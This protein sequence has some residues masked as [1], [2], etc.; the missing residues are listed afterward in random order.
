[1]SGAGGDSIFCPCALARWAAALAGALLI[2]AADAF[3]GHAGALAQSSG[4]QGSGQSTQA[5]TQ[6]LAPA[7][8][9][10]RR[11]LTPG[12][13]E[14]PLTF[15]PLRSFRVREREQTR[16]GA[17]E[18]RGGGVLYSPNPHMGGLSGLEGLDGGKRMIAISD[19]GLWFGFDLKI[20]DK[21][22]LTGV[23][24]G[25]VAPMLDGDGVAM[26]RKSEADTEGLALRPRADGGNDL[27]VSFEGMPRILIYPD[28]N[29][30]AGREPLPLPADAR[31]YLRWNR[32]LESLAYAE[33]GPLKGATVAIGEL[34]RDREDRLPGWII[35]P[36][37]H[38]RPFALLAS[39]NYAA[40]DAAFLPDG[41]LLLLERRFN[42]TQG[43]GMRIRRFDATDLDGADG[44]KG[45]VL[46]DA[47]LAY[48]IDNMEG[49]S[50]DVDE[51][52][53]V[54][55]TV[56]SDDNRSILQRTLLIRFELL[57]D[58]R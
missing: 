1:M 32:G 27:M 21:G 24:D 22:M 35:G 48:Q 18:W 56:V 49:L 34:D 43:V 39:D 37:G 2:V 30:A 17:L 4:A 25:W 53:R 11:S 44:L 5:P 36:D 54:L 50:V 13:H 51:R 58:P 12:H 19:N 46:I 52:G 47:N 20:D 33:A 6:T 14:L 10:D 40:T 42:L 26:I 45:E 9:M 41:D 29:S 55:L 38:P 7:P 57:D 31:R 8:T 28:E 16:F 23:S 15:Q 3:S